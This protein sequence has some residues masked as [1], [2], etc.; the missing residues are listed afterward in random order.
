LG[1]LLAS[2][3]MLGKSDK[4]AVSAPSAPATRPP[5]GHGLG[6]LLQGVKSPAEAEAALVAAGLLEGP[7]AP[8]GLRLPKWY[9]FAA[10][11]LLLALAVLIVFNSASPLGLPQL[12]FCILAIGLGAVL[13]TVPFLRERRTNVSVLAHNNLPKWIIDQSSD[14]QGGAK[15][16]V[17]H[18]HPPVFVGEVSAGKNGQPAVAL[19][20]IDGTSA[21]SAQAMEQLTREASEFY[22]SKTEQ[23]I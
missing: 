1:E 9:F 11:L 6:T 21:V 13:C 7:D 20:W 12:L 8:A 19:V 22:R 10:D 3:R 4:T 17:V 18:L 23:T 2:G 5:L 16:F 14:A 15:C